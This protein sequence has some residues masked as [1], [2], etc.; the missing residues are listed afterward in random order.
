VIDGAFTRYWFF[1]HFLFA[2]TI[3]APTDK[4]VVFPWILLLSSFGLFLGYLSSTFLLSG[5]AA[6]F[7][8]RFLECAWLFLWSIGLF[9]AAG[10]SISG[11]L[12][13]LAIG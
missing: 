10:S 12:N 4:E 9:I 2:L 3:F 5:I 7:D 6:M 8:K 11:A 1:S 13:S